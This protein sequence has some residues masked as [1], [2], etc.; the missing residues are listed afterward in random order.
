MFGLVGSGRTEVAK[1]IFGATPADGGAVRLNGAA[2]DFAHAVAGGARP[3]RHADRGPQGRR[4]GARRQRASTM[5]GWRAFRATRRTASSTARSARQ[6]VGAKIRELSIRLARYRPAGAPAFRRQPAEGGARQMAA[7]REHPALH[8]RRAD[9]R[10]RHRHQGR[11]L[12]DDP[13]PR[14]QRRRGAADL[15]GDAG[16]ARHGRPAAGHARRPASSPSSR[17]E[18]FRPEAVFAHA[19]GLAAQDARPERLH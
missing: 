7:G 13:R 19:A 4:A 1:A 14:R 12:P 8:L 2:A 3:R 5:P 16:G 17:R 11:D 9:A 6:L 15:L 18:A 10:R